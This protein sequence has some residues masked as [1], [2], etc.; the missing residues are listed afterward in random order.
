[1]SF[2]QW[3]FRGNT[4]NSGINLHLYEEML[5]MLFDQLNVFT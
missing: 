1:M 3:P 2:S 5:T 4:V